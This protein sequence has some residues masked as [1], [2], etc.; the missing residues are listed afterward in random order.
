VK[1]AILSRVT[2]APEE[3]VI[4]SYPLSDPRVNWKWKQGVVRD[5]EDDRENAAEQRYCEQLDWR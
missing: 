1:K 4:W 2:C 5:V 3:L